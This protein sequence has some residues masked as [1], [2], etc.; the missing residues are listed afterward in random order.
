MKMILKNTLLTHR[1]TS[2]GTECHASSLWRT[3]ANI[4][5]MEYWSRNR[6]LEACSTSSRCYSSH[7]FSFRDKIS[8]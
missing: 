3:N 8:R 7:N 2:R 4:G 5:L 6:D 1:L